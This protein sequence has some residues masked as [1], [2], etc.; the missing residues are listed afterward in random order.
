MSAKPKCVTV[1]AETSKA[2]HA[3]VQKTNTFQAIA[4][5]N[6]TKVDIQIRFVSSSPVS[7]G[8]HDR[9]AFTVLSGC[10]HG[11]A[12]VAFTDGIAGKALLFSTHVFA[13]SDSLLL[14]RLWCR[15]INK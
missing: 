8:W 11:L 1:S 14:H 4:F 9:N 6:I 12:V 13:G 2:G 7:T 10:R 5:Q 15:Q 3:K